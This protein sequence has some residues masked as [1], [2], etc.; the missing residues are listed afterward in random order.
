MEKTLVCAL[1]FNSQTKIHLQHINKMLCSCMM[2]RYQV[3]L[4]VA[5]R[6]RFEENQSLKCEKKNW[7]EMCLC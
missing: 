5:Q 6:H 4:C 2:P 3:W 1:L 7:A